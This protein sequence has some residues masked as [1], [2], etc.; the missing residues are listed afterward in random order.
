ML[1]QRQGHEGWR[2]GPG[3]HLLLSMS[4]DGEKVR[5][6]TS[7]GGGR[8]R[9]SRYKATSEAVSHFCQRRLIRVNYYV[10]NVGP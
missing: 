5:A 6:P 3:L 9:N 10:I 7:G 2:Q 4:A 8:A 1:K